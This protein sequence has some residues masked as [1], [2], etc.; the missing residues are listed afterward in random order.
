MLYLTLALKIAF[1]VQYDNPWIML[2]EFILYQFQ[3]KSNDIERVLSNN[4]THW[5]WWLWLQPQHAPPAVMEDLEAV[6]IY[7]SDQH[8]S[9][10]L[11]ATQAR[12]FELSC[13]IT[14]HAVSLLQW[15]TVIKHMD[16][17]GV[18]TSKCDAAAGD[19]QCVEMIT[20]TRTCSDDADALPCARVIHV[21]GLV[22]TGRSIN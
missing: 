9:I 21:D 10:N 20:I 19:A 1:I 6:I 11:H 2:I 5:L 8:A 14:H 15:T 13:K 16:T 12:I 17:V 3:S 22:A 4:G 18:I 7:F